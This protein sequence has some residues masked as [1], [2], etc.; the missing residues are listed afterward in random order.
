MSFQST[1]LEAV[2]EPL[3]VGELQTLF[4]KLDDAAVVKAL[5]GPKRR[6]PKGH[7]AWVLWHCFVV[8][9]YLGLSSTAELLRVLH[10]NPYIARTVGI[11]TVLD[12]PHKATF[13]RFFKRLASPKIL[14]RLKDV[15]RSFVRRYY[16]ELPGFGER[17][18]LDST[19]LKAW[20]NGGKKPKTDPDAGW[21]IKKGS[22]GSKE[23]TYGWKLHLLVDCESEMPIAANVSAGNVN[24]S[25]RAS[26]VLREARREV[27][28][29][30]PRF[31]IADKGYASRAMFHL[32]RRQY[33]ADPVIDIPATSVH[34][35]A[36]EGRQATLAGYRSLKK[37]RTAVERA[38]SRLKGQR[39]LNHITVRGW[40][41]VTA[42]C[43]LSLIALQVAYSP[44]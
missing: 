18:A 1:I 42:H 39:S 24:D 25:K 4:G 41:K 40:R 34:M 13:S 21:S 16:S 38:Y 32:V 22:Q 11:E 23:Y 9:Y 36:Q 28:R 26:N 2:A 35:L 8:K 43:Y 17:V 12:I 29:F 27:P 7:S 33:N 31:I 15:S 5:I 37:Q 10:R 44:T 20:S 14:P 6:G 19:T 3:L 30:H